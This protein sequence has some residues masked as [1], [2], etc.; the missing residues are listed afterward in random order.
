MKSNA[1]CQKAVGLS[2][3]PLRGGLGRNTSR[4]VKARIRLVALLSFML[5]GSACSIK[6]EVSVQVPARILQ[7]KTA[8]FQELVDLV[9]GYADKIHSLSSTTMR[10]T[11]RSGRME[12]GKLQEYRSAPGYILL[13]RPESIRLS[14]QNP[15]TKTSILDLVSFGDDF[16][17]W[18][19]TKNRFYTG[20]NS[21]KE[22]EVE[23]SGE[24]PSFTARP[25]D[26]LQSILPAGLPVAQPGF[27]TGMEEAQDVA[28]KYYVLSLYKIEDGGRLAPVRKFW[29]D[30][31]DLTIARQQVYG[32]AGEL[33][34]ITDY[35]RYSQMEGIQV[36]LSIKIDRPTDGYSLDL[37]FKSWRVNP[38]FP[39]NAFVL[40][41]PPGAE[42]I[43][44]KEKREGLSFLS[45]RF[46]SRPLEPGVPSEPISGVL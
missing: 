11:F 24:T 12:S 36:P 16:S 45:L 27:G 17:L 28:T 44:L 20:K 30:R 18:V 31:A 42:R 25:S 15:V 13:H 1:I 9:N 39:E 22:F 35:S 34:G 46:G 37:E 7:A 8:T 6:K 40:T 3:A 38:Q 21:T 32:N 23:G 43:Q 5:A 14:V 41:P 2:A 19:P 29:I 26:I 33:A 4:Q 10:V